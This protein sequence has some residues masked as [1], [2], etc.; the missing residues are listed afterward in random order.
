MRKKF[1]NILIVIA[2]LCGVFL[3]EVFNNLMH[4]SN[5]FIISC[6]QHDENY[7]L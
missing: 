7:Y 3:F 4:S 6:I 5:S 1:R 2:V